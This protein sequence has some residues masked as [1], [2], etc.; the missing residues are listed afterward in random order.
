MIKKIFDKKLIKK[1]DDGFNS[2]QDWLSPDSKTAQ[3][4][5]GRTKVK[6]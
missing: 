1:I 3:G 4:D 6:T 2:E 5:K